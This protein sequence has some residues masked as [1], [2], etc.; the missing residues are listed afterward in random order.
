V[1]LV[2]LHPP[3]SPEPPDPAALDGL[4][5]ELVAECHRVATIIPCTPAHVAMAWFYIIEA[6]RSPHI[7]QAINDAALGF[8]DLSPEDKFR[9]FRLLRTLDPPPR[10]TRRSS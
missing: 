10:I 7:L 9:L 3:D 8:Y 6:V 5:V 2:T 4:P 1:R